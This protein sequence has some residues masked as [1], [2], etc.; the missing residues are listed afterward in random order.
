[1]KVYL[2]GIQCDNLVFIIHMSCSDQGM[3]LV[4]CTTCEPSLRET[5]DI[6]SPSCFVVHGC[7][8]VVMFLCFRT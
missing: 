6:L 7:L 5:L 1:M 8:Y 4:H 2:F 3:W